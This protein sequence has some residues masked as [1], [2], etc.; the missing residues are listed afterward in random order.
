M[1]SS[2]SVSA[3]H[4]STCS[5]IPRPI[6]EVKR[7]LG[8]KLMLMYFLEGVGAELSWA[9]PGA[10]TSDFGCVP[11]HQVDLAELLPVLMLLKN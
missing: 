4:F 8:L 3:E 11:E 1:H 2:G 7:L 5:I 6:T 9:K 10:D